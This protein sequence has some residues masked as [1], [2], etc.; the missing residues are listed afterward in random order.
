MRYLSG[1]RVAFEVSHHP[2]RYTAQE[3]AQVEH[4]PG[5]LVAK[6]VMVVADGGPVMAVV[7][8]TARVSLPLLRDVLGAREV[9]L[10]Q[11][12]EFDHVF[13]DCEVGAMPPLGNLYGVPVY[14]DA[15]LT[16]APVIFF[17][18]GTHEDVI[19]I[20]YADFARLVHPRV[21]TFAAEREAA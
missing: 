5:R 13:P 1:E 12:S 10:A 21:A 19:S 6:V 15:A 11:E 20:S 14:G 4:I 17:N 3:V 16:K 2:P 8:A 9:R 7:P 18:A